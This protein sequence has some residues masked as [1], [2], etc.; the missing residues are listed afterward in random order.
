MTIILN[1]IVSLLHKYQQKTLYLFVGGWNTL[2]GFITYS[3]FYYFLSDT[4]HYLILLIP[5]NII[6]ITNAYICYKLWVFK[7]VGNYLREY[8]RFYF[9]YGIGFIIN[10][11]L[12]AVL[13]ELIY[14]NPIA[15][16][17]ITAIVTVIISYLGHKNYSFKS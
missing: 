13:V 17:A 10:L 7:T 3:L 6:S 4:V 8:L 16:Q 15:A 14:L 5:V 2:F 9:V 1:R 11:L 12:M